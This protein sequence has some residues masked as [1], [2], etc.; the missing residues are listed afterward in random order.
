[1]YKF[2][3]VQHLRDT[4]HPDYIDA[5]NKLRY[6]LHVSVCKNDKTAL[7]AARDEITFLRAKLQQHLGEKGMGMNYDVIQQHVNSCKTP[8]CLTCELQGSKEPWGLD[9]EWVEVKKTST[10]ANLGSNKK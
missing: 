2:D 9:D 8:G 4:K 7:A 3:H 1:M 5:L 6:D 10:K